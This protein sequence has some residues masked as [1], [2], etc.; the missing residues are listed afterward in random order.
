MLV[1]PPPL[2]VYKHLCTQTQERN[3][4]K[5]VLIYKLHIDLYVFVKY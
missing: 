4:D 5:Y 3:I 1:S 2:Y